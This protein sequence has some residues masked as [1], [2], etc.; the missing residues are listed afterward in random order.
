MGA[1]VL[2]IG[3]VHLGRRPGRLPSR[4]LRGLGLDAEDLSPAAAL[5]TAIDEA[6]RR[7]VLAVCFA[8]DVVESANDVFEAYGLLERALRRL[9]EAGIPAYAVAGNHDVRALP[10]LAA[11]SDHLTLVGEGG[12]WQSVPLL[13]G[14]QRVAT[15]VGWSFPRQSFGTSPLEGFPGEL[16]AEE[17]VLGLLHADLDAGASVHAP[18]RRRELVEL[19]PDAWLLGHI[20]KPSEL[21]GTRPIGY[22]GSLVGLDAGEPG[23]RGA[24]VAELGPGREVRMSRVPVAPLR[25]EGIEVS[26][27]GIDDEDALLGALR[28]A[29]EARLRALRGDGALDALR[30]IAARVRLTGRTRHGARFRAPDLHERLARLAGGERAEVPIVVESVSHELRPLHDLD[31]LARRGDPPGLLARDLIALSGDGSGE[32][33]RELL[34]EA[35]ETL[36][37]ALRARSIWS[38][39]ER[40][41]ESDDA[42]RAR[43]LRAGF[44]ALDELLS[45]REATR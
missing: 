45:Q 42:L 11:H 6:I 20:H 41:E 2:C 12:R 29:F 8:G 37:G 36:D 22:L 10:R 44:E 31:Q 7:R 14:G 34:R 28:E 39:L 26:V 25:W 13:S 43:L 32:E 15:L 23:E 18:V 38:A 33:T 30:C 40:P 19:R 1:R 21:E 24:W 35:R 9:A 16:P 17:P 5:N 4:V 3:D 27:E